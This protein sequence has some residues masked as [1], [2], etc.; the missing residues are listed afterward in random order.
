MPEPAEALYIAK[1]DIDVVG[2]CKVK[3]NQG[4]LEQ[5]YRC[6]NWLTSSCFDECF[7]SYVL[8]FLCWRGLS[9]VRLSPCSDGK[10]SPRGLA[11]GSLVH[12]R[13]FLCLC[14]MCLPLRF[15]IFREG[16]SGTVS[17]CMKKNKT[18]QIIAL[19]RIVFFSF[20]FYF[21]DK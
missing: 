17:Y 11:Y 1:R 16:S 6:C 13:G 15:P 14:M 7:I 4:W 20:Y 18:P 8:L 10:L 2:V 19:L 9:Q 5:R 12:C 21:V 3:S